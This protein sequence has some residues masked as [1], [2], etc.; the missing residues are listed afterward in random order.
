[1]K[2]V[3]KKGFTMVEILI[4]VAII[5]VLAGIA[6]PVVTHYMNEGRNEYNEKLKDQLLISGKE[7]FTDN[8]QKLPVKSYTGVYRNGQDFSYVSLPEMQSN[9]YISKEFVDSEGNECTESYVYVKQ[10]INSSEYKWY[11]CLR[12]TDKNGNVYDPTKDT[13]SEEEQ[14]ACNITDWGDKENPSC[15]VEA[16]EYT[17]PT[18]I[19]EGKVYNPKAVKL[20]EVKE[21]RQIAYIEIINMTT[22]EIVGIELND[23]S[24]VTQKEIISY[25]NKH[26]KEGIEGEYE[27]HVVD[28]GGNS[29]GNACAKFIIDNTAPK[30]SYTEDKKPQTD[31]WYIPELN[32]TAKCTDEGVINTLKNQII[33][34]GKTYTGETTH[35]D[36][37]KTASI[38]TMPKKYTTTCEDKA[39]NKTTKDKNYYV[40]SDSYTTGDPIYCK[41]TTP[42]SSW[43]G[44][45]KTTSMTVTC[46]VPTDKTA[47]IDVSKM[48]LKNNLGTLSKA[49]TGVYNTNENK[50][51]EYKLTYTA[52][53]T[54]QLG[55]DNII[56]NE[57]FVT[58]GGQK[59]KKITSGEIN[60]DTKAPVITY[61]ANKNKVSEKSYYA[62]SS[63]SPFSV[64][65]SCSDTGSGVKTLSSN[66]NVNSTKHTTNPYTYTIKS[67]MKGFKVSGTCED[68]AGNVTSNSATY[69]VATYSAHKDCG[70]KQY[71]SCVNSSCDCKT[72]KSCRNSSCDCALYKRGSSCTCATSSCSKR[73]A[74]NKGSCKTYKTNKNCTTKKVTAKSC[75]VTWN[76]SYPSCPSG[77]TRKSTGYKVCNAGTAGSGITTVKAF[78]NCQKCTTTK[79]CSAYNYTTGS[80]CPCTAYT[81]TKYNRCSKAGCETRESCR[82]KTCGCQTHYSCRAKTCGVESYKSCYHY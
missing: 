74:C 78:S 34:N 14:I 54:N 49:S 51:V 80:N 76:L 61:K 5:A 58:A 44:L 59:N 73:S 56:I 62:V 75:T 37:I 57:G 77:Y 45:N 31:G 43:L 23:N 35:K 50:V 81:C 38:S 41:N 9:N 32:V 27:I 21:D 18:A 3:N 64:T 55:S 12:C 1:M 17:D 70:V 16:A 11:A 63:S 22:E 42:S 40:R 36:T 28:A 79:T 48:V 24:E 15:N 47:T 71:K 52:S 46:Y 33:Q 60:V 39:G 68:N 69:N 72:Y 67:P 30:V 6:I 2:K 10:K 25:I 26:M 20:K 4:T 53:K 19:T 29:T 13:S 8:R 65:V 82:A 66:S 7:Y